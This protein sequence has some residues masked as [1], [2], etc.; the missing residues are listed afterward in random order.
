MLPTWTSTPK[1]PR[2]SL[3]PNNLSWNVHASCITYASC[4]LWTWRL[5]LW[6]L[7]GPLGPGWMPRI[8][9]REQWDESEV[10]VREKKAW[11]PWTR[12]SEWCLEPNPPYL[13]NSISP[14]F[15]RVHHS[16]GSWSM[17]FSCHLRLQVPGGGC[18]SV[19]SLL[20]AD[21]RCSVILNSDAHYVTLCIATF[22]FRCLLRAAAAS[23]LRQRIE[24]ASA[25]RLHIGSAVS[26]S[27]FILSFS[28]PCGAPL[29]SSLMQSSIA[30][31]RSI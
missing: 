23:I 12:C 19:D 4:L 24:D 5:E 25:S 2:R 22:S 20:G 26:K 6:L 13:V 15:A 31:C 11:Q 10:E 30:L 7:W 9:V 3:W 28:P 27:C 14:C 21:L 1:N 18:A 17:R 8:R 16:F 29:G